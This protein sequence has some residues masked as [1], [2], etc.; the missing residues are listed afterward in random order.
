MQ[1]N[2]PLRTRRQ[3][4]TWLAIHEVAAAAVSED[5]IHGVTTGKIAQRAGISPRTFF[6]YFDTKEDA[7]LGLRMPELPEA[8]LAE[9]SANQTDGKLL[10]VTRLMSRV[11]AT[12]FPTQVDSTRSRELVS[13]HEELRQRLVFVVVRAR[14]LVLNRTS[15]PD[16]DS[17]WSAAGMPTDENQ[18]TALIMFASTTMTLAWRNNPERRFPPEDKLLR[19]AIDMLEQL[20]G[21]W[22]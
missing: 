19:Q 8:A 10:R 11:V 1:T 22:L 13:R 7:V 9:F 3:Q 20:S 6:N 15:D 12:S 16:G 21:D 2:V 17:W 18:R 4:E 14:D 5:G